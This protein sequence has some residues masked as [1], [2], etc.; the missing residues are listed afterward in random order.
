MP[1]PA[2]FPQEVVDALR[3]AK[4]LG[5]RA[6]T[7]HRVTGV[8]VVV[9]GR[10]FVRSWN[11]KPTG[12]SRAFRPDGPRVRTPVRSQPEAMGRVP[13]PPPGRQSRS[14][15][16]IRRVETASRTRPTTSSISGIQEESLR[17]SEKSMR[18]LRIGR[19]NRGQN[20]PTTDRAPHVVT[21]RAQIEDRE[22]AP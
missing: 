17:P 12:W 1:S 13:V 18:R 16:D 11:D 10:G 8:W 5:I 22:I 19:P 6:G 3:T 14:R 4:I 7:A 15:W 20:R 9:E 2:P 21:V